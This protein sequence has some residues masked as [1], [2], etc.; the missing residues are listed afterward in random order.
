[1]KINLLLICLLLILKFGMSQNVKESEPNN[2]FAQS[3][4]IKQDST[5]SGTVGM[6]GDANDFFVGLSVKAGTLKIYISF[7]N[8]SGNAGS[9]LYMTANNKAQSNIGTR[10]I[11][12]P[13]FGKKTDSLIIYCR[14]ADTIYIK[15]NANGSFDYDLSFKVLSNAKDDIEP[16]NTLAQAGQFGVQ[17]TIHGQVGYYSTTRDADDYHK[18]AMSGAG[19]FVVYTDY[20]NTSNS[21][22]AD[23]YIY[24]YNKNGTS[25]ENKSL[26]NRPVGVLLKDTLYVHCR[27]QDSLIIR[28]SS[29]SGQCFSYSI[30]YEVE[31]V[32]GGDI[33]P[34]NNLST[35]QLMH[36]NDTIYGRSGYSGTTGDANDYFVT[37][38]PAGG[39]VKVYR[40]M[41]STSSASTVDAYMY[42][43]NSIGQPLGSTG[44][45]NPV[46]GV[47]V[48]D[49]L[50]IN[51]REQDSMYF[52]VQAS[53]GCYYYKLWYVIVPREYN[54]VE[55]NNT[56]NSATVVDISKPIEGS[57]YYTDTQTDHYDYFKFNNPSVGNVK[58]KLVA[59]RNGTASGEFMEIYLTNKNLVKIGAKIYSDEFINETIE[60]NCMPK[61]TLVLV[62]HSFICFTYSIEI[63]LESAFPQVDID[64]VRT[65]N[66]YAFSADNLKNVS[67]LNWNLGPSDNRTGRFVDKEF[68]TGSGYVSLLT[69]NSTCNVSRT[70]L[71]SWEVKGIEYYSPKQAGAG[72]DAL[73]QVF[74]GGIDTSMKV[75]L[76]QGVNRI[77]PKLKYASPKRNEL[78]VLFDLHFAD[79]G[80]YDV[81]I[82]LPGEAELVYKDG[83]EVNDMEYPYT[84]SKVIGADKVR[85]NRDVNYI[86]NVGNRGNVK[87]SGVITYLIW[88]KSVD[89]KFK[90]KWYAPPDTGT[91]YVDYEDTIVSGKWADLKPFYTNEFRKPT[92]ID[93]FAGIAYDGYMMRIEI[94]TISPRGIYSIPF[95]ATSKTNGDKKF[96]TYTAKPNMY[97][98][99]GNGSQ[100]DQIENGAFEAIDGMDDVLGIVK[101]DKTPLGLVT[102]ALKGTSRHLA[103]NAQ[104]ATAYV[105]VWTG[106]NN[107][108]YESLPSDFDSKVSAA[109]GH[110]MST[111]GD[112]ALD[113]LVD[114]GAGRM[115][116][117]Q[118]DDLKRYL[119][120]SPDAATKSVLM[121]LD[122]LK[123]IEDMRSFVKNAYKTQK[124]LKTLYGKTD[125]LL[126][127]AR[128]CPEL[129]RQ[130]DQLLKEINNEMKQREVEEK[131]TESIQS[132]D[133][134]AIYGPNGITSNRFLNLGDLHTF[135]VTF[136]NVDTATAAA[137]IVMIDVPL[138]T[139]AFDLSTFSFGSF[140]IGDE[141]YNVPPQRSEFVVDI[142]FG[143]Q[144]SYIVRFMAKLN[145]ET[146][147]INCKF[148][149]LDTLS[150]DLP[151][152]EGFLPPNV[153]APEGEGS[154][155]Y[156]VSPKEGIADGYKILSQASIVFDDNPPISTNTWENTIDRKAGTSRVSA[157]NTGNTINLKFT[158]ADAQS[159]I[160]FYYLYMS[161]N[162]GPWN[163]ITGSAAED[164]VLIGETGKTYDF[165][166]TSIDKVANQEIKTPNAEASVSVLVG[167]KMVSKPKIDIFPNPNK[168]LIEVHADGLSENVQMEIYDIAGKLM[169]NQI[170]DFS[171]GKRFSIMLNS[172]LNGIY[173]V[174]L[175]SNTG[176]FVQKIIINR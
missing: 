38:L 64:V 7:N 101:L 170:L 123:T 62:I 31:K 16:N 60:I 85:T 8:T 87:A 176:V 156:S 5:I 28:T 3:N 148:I 86:L 95:T 140:R 115:L 159:G 97:G 169:H 6:S 33:E 9:D 93:S 58:L 138:D 65:G 56:Y 96:I 67:S 18:V 84:Y 137:Q 128:D 118:A 52:R 68:N 20:I 71:V 14:Q 61:D 53:S 57:I 108:I 161:E 92:A 129:Q 150:R 133:P 74:G 162:G 127:L 30:R 4:L 66:L 165:Y 154:I 26:T 135:M 1:M 113:K 47:S 145:K 141:I 25:L 11:T 120:N 98:S 82:Q 116:K 99:C 83:F 144:K 22:G 70:D 172:L 163:V 106:Q 42:A 75:E 131:T 136:E 146:G 54:D 175:N 166:S 158:G 39:T 37:W 167:I 44:S 36:Y 76:R 21:S 2:T 91:Y 90:N 19:T 155:S 151:M 132:Y 79:L 104:I 147:N 114:V 80:M 34:N 94:P 117:G 51:C 152:L 174:R 100:I 130:I 122:E 121:A 103:L 15:L 164:L 173:I 10:N 134:N 157:T 41:V 126:K 124:D 168:G 105:N 171:D 139:T 88:P 72:G 69:K 29:G 12:N 160:D 24:V 23:F 45:F 78:Q 102:K 109:N 142:D 110:A 89:V 48:T 125:R 111:V 43:Y 59:K 17:D 46:P 49:S 77:I 27:E 13:G 40:T 107:T 63:T 153:K 32:Q 149:T 50:I 143:K 55:P 81:V 73:M 119:A 35:A 112:I